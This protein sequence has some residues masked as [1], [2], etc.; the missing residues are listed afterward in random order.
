M[1]SSHIPNGIAPVHNS[2]LIRH[3]LQARENVTPNQFRE[4]SSG[5]VAADY[6]ETNTII[7]ACVMFV[8]ILIA[9]NL[10]ILRDVIAGLKVGVIY[11]HR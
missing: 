11:H 3:V 10:P 6:V 8:A 9:W 5:M 2:T 7:A 4:S 1:F